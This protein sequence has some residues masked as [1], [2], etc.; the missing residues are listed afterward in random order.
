MEGKSFLSG[1]SHFW[2]RPKRALVAK[3]HA[4]AAP[5]GI[6]TE[7][8]GMKPQQPHRFFAHLL[9]V[10]T[11]AA[12]CLVALSASANMLDG[13]EIK[14]QV[15]GKRIYLSTPM[16]GEFPLFYKPDGR[17]DGSGEA[18]GLGRFVRPNDSGQWWVAG[19]RLCQ[20]WQTWYDGKTMCFTLTQ[21]GEGRL[22]WNQD[23][24]DTGL[25]RI[26]N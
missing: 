24:G 9:G 11:L 1:Q 16:G 23:N 3:G 21:M 7:F 12:A 4:A 13:N 17:V 6:T 15:S 25:A 10:F 8:D 22:R 2:R 18:S 20:R 19:N 26:G 5:L 14:R